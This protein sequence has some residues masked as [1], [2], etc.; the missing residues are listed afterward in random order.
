MA[1]IVGRYM[2][3]FH[4]IERTRRGNGRLGVDAVYVPADQ[5][6]FGF[7]QP[8]WRGF[9]AEQQQRRTG[10]PAVLVGLEKRRAAGDGEIAVAPRIFR[11]AMTVALGPRLEP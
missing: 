9:N 11:E 7:R 10:D 2:N 6:R 8:P 1:A 3:V 4:R 5:R